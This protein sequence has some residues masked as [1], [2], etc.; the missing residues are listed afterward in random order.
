MREHERPKDRGT[1]P[2]DERTEAPV[3]KGR[4]DRLNLGEVK[5]HA[6]GSFQ[7]LGDLVV[8]LL[9]V[10]TRTHPTAMIAQ[11]NDL[12]GCATR[13]RFRLASPAAPADP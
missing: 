13:W 10:D 3:E 7:G 5:T 11:L 9:R 6:A 4:A 8:D 12:H 1:V 2:R